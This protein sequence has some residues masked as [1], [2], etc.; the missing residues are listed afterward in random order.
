MKVKTV[1]ELDDEVESVTLMGTGASPQTV[2]SPFVAKW[3]TVRL[4]QVTS[5]FLSGKV[6]EKQAHA[7]SRKILR[8]AQQ[9]E[10]RRA[11][12]RILDAEI[13][14]LMKL[15]DGELK[16]KIADMERVSTQLYEQ[17]EQLADRYARLSD[18]LYFREL[19]GHTPSTDEFEDWIKS[20]T[21]FND[22]LG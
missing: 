18:L 22:G 14:D 19:E 2:V 17:S 5:N 21:A 12:L 10:K 13:A 15:P 11:K 9:E 6:T 3:A 4:A 1:K 7:R 20:K 16:E 8:D